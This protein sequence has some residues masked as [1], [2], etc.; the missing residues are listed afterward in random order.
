MAGLLFIGL[1][2]VLLFTVMW[3]STT[4]SL[5][6]PLPYVAAHCLKVAGGIA[7][8]LVGSKQRQRLRPA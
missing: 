7:G 5:A 3:V 6:Q 4:E 2:R 1:T 8:E